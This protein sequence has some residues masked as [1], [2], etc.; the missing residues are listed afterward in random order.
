MKRLTLWTRS[1]PDSFWFWA[2]FLLAVLVV[3]GLLCLLLYDPFNIFDGWH[4]RY[5]AR[6]AVRLH[7][8]AMT[9]GSVLAAFA[10]VVVYTENRTRGQCASPTTLSTLFVLFMSIASVA[11]ICAVCTSALYLFTY[12]N[13][14]ESVTRGSLLNLTALSGGAGFLG[15]LSFLTAFGIHGYFTSKERG[16]ITTSVAIAGFCYMALAGL[17]V[18][19][20][21]F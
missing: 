5:P 8:A 2:K 21:V 6:A 17:Q 7:E 15:V 12:V 18:A 20:W 13:I 19:C 3:I 1:W 4:D 16:R 9:I 11:L 14:V 10:M